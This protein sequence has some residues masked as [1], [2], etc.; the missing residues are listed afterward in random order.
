VRQLLLLDEEQRMNAKDAKKHWWFS[1]SFHRLD[2]EEVYQRA[3][4][5]WRPR[6]LKSPV[7]KMIDANQ[8]NELPTLQ[9]ACLFGQRNHRRRSPAPVDPPYKPYPS[10]MSLSLLPKRR[11]GFSGV[12]SD[13]VRTAIRENWS[14]GRMRPPTVDPKED[15]V[16]ALV[17]DTEAEE[18]DPPR[19]GTDLQDAS[20]KIA[21]KGPRRPSMSPLGS[22]LRPLLQNQSSMVQTR[23]T[24]A[25]MASEYP[26]VKVRERK[27]VQTFISVSIPSAEPSTEMKS[28]RFGM[29]ENAPAVRGDPAIVEGILW[30]AKA[31]TAEDRTS[32]GR[33]DVAMPDGNVTFHQKKDELALE[34]SSHLLMHGTSDQPHEIAEEEAL[35]LRDSRQKPCMSTYSSLEDLKLMTAERPFAHTALGTLERSNWPSKLRSPLQSAIAR[36]R[37]PSNVKRRRGS[38]YDFELDEESEHEKCGLA[39]LTLD[40]EATDF[41]PRTAWKKA[42]MQID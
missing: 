12:M 37:R 33:S 20:E 32:R 40:P 29:T 1:N 30:A 39:S 41:G 7:I 4:K 5:H 26:R 15:E 24:K 31:S 8:Q 42:R 34:K 13:E 2:F 10:R 36:P 11:P 22:P 28:P 38:I 14:P 18:L 16:L 9:Q 6:T 27:A 21:M 25:S 35:R 19:D 3:I 17:P 23:T